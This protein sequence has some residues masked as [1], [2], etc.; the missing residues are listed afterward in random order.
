MQGLHRTTDQCP[1]CHGDGT[2]ECPCCSCEVTCDHCYGSGWNPERLDAIG[3]ISASDRFV[4]KHRATVGWFEGNR[5]MGRQ[6]L[7]GEHRL[8]IDPYVYA[9]VKTQ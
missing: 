1:E 9:E 2:V 8:P 6:T 5:F 3:W 4:R 7:D